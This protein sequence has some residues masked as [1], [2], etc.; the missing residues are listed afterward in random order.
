MEKIT[1]QG[2]KSHCC[3]NGQQHVR[4]LIILALLWKEGAHFWNWKCVPCAIML[5]HRQTIQIMYDQIIEKIFVVFTWSH[6]SHAPVDTF[7]E[8]FAQK[9]FSNIS[10]VEK[11]WTN[12]I[13]VVHRFQDNFYFTLQQTRFNKISCLIG[14]VHGNTMIRFTFRIQF[15]TRAL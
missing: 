9:S 1:V 4:S 3:K 13:G 14:I 11:N 10:L 7:S 12:E 8:T 15:K 5:I 6:E 2:V